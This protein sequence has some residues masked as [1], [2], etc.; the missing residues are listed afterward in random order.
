MT[1]KRR[2]SADIAK[3]ASACEH[4]E[5]PVARYKVAWRRCIAARDRQ[6]GAS[7][8]RARAADGRCAHCL[9]HARTFAAPPLR[10]PLRFCIYLAAH[11]NCRRL[12]AHLS[13]AHLCVLYPCLMAKGRIISRQHRV[14]DLPTVRPPRV[15]LPAPRTTTS[16][17]ARMRAHG[18]WKTLAVFSPSRRVKQ[19]SLARKTRQDAG[20]AGA[21]LLPACLTPTG[22]HRFILRHS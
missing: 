19:T 13:Q 11:C 16:R 15:K 18:F 6:G 7:R 12:D 10:L 2:R 17:I 8:R 3:K 20:C 9:H 5:T 14:P 4:I 21:L 1:L 22:R